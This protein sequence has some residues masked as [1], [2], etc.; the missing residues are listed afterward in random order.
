MD[1]VLLHLRKY[2]SASVEAQSQR[3]KEVKKTTTLNYVL[4][5]K[6]MLHVVKLVF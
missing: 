5:T 2:V 6:D 4:F 1:T 3:K